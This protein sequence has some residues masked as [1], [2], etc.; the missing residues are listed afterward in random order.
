MLS[1]HM[2]KINLEG[3]HDFKEL[4]L[5]NKRMKALEARKNKAEKNN[6]QI[7]PFEFLFDHIYQL[8][9]QFVRTFK[10]AIFD[11]LDWNNMID[12]FKG[13]M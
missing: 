10:N 9:Q 8:S 2:I 6:K 5:I 4:K 13:A 3:V 1:M 11:F 7:H 12:L